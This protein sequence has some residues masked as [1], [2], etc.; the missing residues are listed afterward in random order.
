[1]F[2]LVS[3]DATPGELKGY[4]A[5]FAEAEF[6]ERT[7]EL[8]RRFDE[9]R[10]RSPADPLVTEI[11]EQAADLG[12]DVSRLLPDDVRNAPIGGSRQRDFLRAAAAG[13]DPAQA[14]CFELLLIR[15]RERWG[16]GNPEAPPW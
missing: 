6:T 5:V 15:L 13:L 8:S 10:G 16:T 4:H 12:H 11:A 7:Y 1:L 14:R 2:E 9:L 3:G